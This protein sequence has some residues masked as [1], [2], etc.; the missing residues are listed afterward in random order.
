MPGKK[1]SQRSRMRKKYQK[2]SA[3]FR[4]KRSRTSLTLR[5]TTY[6]KKFLKDLKNSKK[7]KK[8]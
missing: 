5:P 2:W 3:K 8:K 1:S 4:L 7:S 6:R